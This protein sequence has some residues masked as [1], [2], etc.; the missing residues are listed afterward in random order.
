M[1]KLNDLYTKKQLEVLK[2]SVVDEPKILITAGAKRAGKTYVL[3]QAFILHMES[4][5]GKGVNFI[6][7]GSNASSIQ[8]NILDDMEKILNIDI[9]MTNKNYF[10]LWGN[11][12]HC[13]AGTN[14]DAWKSVR[15]FT[16][17]GALL[18]EGTA[19]HNTFIKEVVSRCS[20]E[21]ARIFIDTNPENPMHPVKTDYIDKNNSRL[22]SG[23]LNVK[24]FHFT[25]YDNNFL[26]K[27]Y[28]ESI[29]NVT[30]SGMFHDRDILGL[31]VA[32]E[33]I[34]YKDFD[35]KKHVIK[36][37]PQDEHIEKY[38][39]GVD[40]GFEHYGSIVVIGVSQTNKYY[41]VEEVAEQY[42]Y[43]EFWIEIANNFQE[44]YRNI[45]FYGD[46]AR[47]EY[48]QQMQEA[49][50]NLYE[51]EK[52]VVAGINIV[53]SL[54][55]TDRLFFLEDKFKKGLEEM[56]LYCWKGGYTGKEEVLK[57]NDDVLD[58][59]RYSIFSDYRNNSNDD[60]FIL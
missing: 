54:L 11:K 23:K 49:N 34:V 59:V 2:C 22:E 17:A 45:V 16:S 10:E 56:F 9:R 24:S 6:I 44:K 57:K 55:K 27:D 3:M 52:A 37:I 21:G 60:F 48:I 26:P 38:I 19:L 32:A 29:E 28:I 47:P 18:N 25:L 7:G 31:W 46:W 50:I 14:S 36:E 5:I 58:S 43:I 13:F 41:L 42:K 20:Y 1:E 53:G 8:R 4:Y 35:I 33:G 51:A 12:I 40:F 39:A 30:P 15:G